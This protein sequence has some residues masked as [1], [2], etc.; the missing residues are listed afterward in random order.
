MAL[1]LYQSPISLKLLQEKSYFQRLGEILHFSIEALLLKED[2]F[3]INEETLAKLVAK[4]LFLYPEPLLERERLKE[5][6][7][8]ILKS[9]IQSEDWRALQN[10]FKDAEA[11]YQEIEGYFAEENKI[12]RP[13]F[14]IFKKDILY[15]LEFKLR[16]EDFQKEQVRLYQ[17]FLNSLYPQRRVKL[18]LLTFLPF[19]FILFEENLKES[20]KDADQKLLNTTQLPLFEKFN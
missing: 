5:E 18:C 8:K 16:K 9:A 15:L 1:R 2:I 7:L 12:L 4:A 13:D 17:K 3:T 14:L 20:S 10:I 11:F 6:A 19:K